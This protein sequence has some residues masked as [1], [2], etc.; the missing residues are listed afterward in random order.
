MI[1]ERYFV[2]NV[3]LLA[4][5]TFAIRG[6]FIAVSGRVRISPRVRDLFSYIPAAIFPAL[7]LP[8]TF[9]HK[10][11]AALLA[12]KERFVTLLVVIV[13]AF[14]VRNTL[15]VI[16]FGLGLLYVIAA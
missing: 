1:N 7:V 2:L 4:T 12:G 11:H 3:L 9:Y 10:G 6:A 14:W 8:A 13:F 15:A 5:G 16:L